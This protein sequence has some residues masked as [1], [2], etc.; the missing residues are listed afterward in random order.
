[1]SDEK[2]DKEKAAAII[3]LFNSFHPMVKSILVGGVIGSIVPVVGT[4]IG[5]I[6][7][8]V[9]WFLWFKNDDNDD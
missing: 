8:G 7:G 2:N 9:A 4:I 1:M 5:G 6:I 3:E